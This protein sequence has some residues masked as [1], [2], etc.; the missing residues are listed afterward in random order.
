MFTR[1]KLLISRVHIDYPS[2]ANNN[3]IFALSFSTGFRVCKVWYLTT[4]TWSSQNKYYKAVNQ[5]STANTVSLWL[6]GD[7]NQCSSIWFALSRH[8]QSFANLLQDLKGYMR[9][10][11]LHSRWTY[12]RWFAVGETTLYQCTFFWS[13]FSS[14]SP[15]TCCKD[16]GP[17]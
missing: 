3:C 8:D 2:A 12:R 17:R 14:P 13:S 11:F 15:T 4:P 6:P 5:P 10:F 16:S 9:I 1:R 7:K